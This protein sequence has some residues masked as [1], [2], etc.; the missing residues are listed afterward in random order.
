[1]NPI[2]PKTNSAPGAGAPASLYLGELAS[3]R[4]TGKLYL[5][6]D[7]GV[8]EIQ[9]GGGG[10]AGSQISTFTGTGSQTA[11]A[12]LTGYSNTTV[13]NYLVSVGG[14]DQR[15]TTDWTISSANG[16]TITF[17]SGAPPNGAPIVVRAFVGAS[18]GGGSGDATSLQGRALADTA[19]TDG[20]AVVWDSANSTWKPDTVSGVG[21]SMWDVN[22]TYKDGDIV[23]YYY[24]VSQDSNIRTFRTYICT[25][26][27]GQA[28]SGLPITGEITGI[29]PLED[30]ID[31]NCWW[32]LLVGDLSSIG[33]HGIANTVPQ[34]NDTIVFSSSI[35]KWKFGT[36]ITKNLQGRALADTAPTDGQALVWDDANGTWKPGTMSGRAWDSAATYTQGDMVATSQRETWICIQNDNT[37]HDPTEAESAWWAPLPADAVSLQLRPVATTAPTDGQAL[38]WD[39]ANGTWKPNSVLRNNGNSEAGCLAVGVGSVADAN[40]ATAIGIG[41]S[42]YNYSSVAIGCGAFAGQNATAINASAYAGTIVIGP[43]TGATVVSIGGY[44]IVNMSND[45]SNL[46]SSTSEIPAIKSKVNEIVSWINNNGGSISPL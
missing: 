19:P 12:P 33:A 9:G 44:N 28:G 29:A 21:G 34:E 31:P 15:P 16:G 36:A 43:E 3:N 24:Y 46:Q 30:F 38:V 26:S 22:T 5:G 6:C 40:N 14:I 35:N 10:T 20:Q 32:G 37:N 25:A 2:I 42:A 27:L 1:M 7:S 4:T 45:I 11:F 41:S 17:T 8:V 23:T 39:D 18:G 13:G